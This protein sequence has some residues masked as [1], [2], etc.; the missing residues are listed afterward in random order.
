MRARQKQGGFVATDATSK[1]KY[2]CES[3]SKTC[4][5]PPEELRGVPVWEY[6]LITIVIFL[7]ASLN[8]PTLTLFV[9]P[10]GFVRVSYPCGF[11]VQ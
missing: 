2:N 10:N 5:L 4:V 3:Q 1:S 8:P 7:S 11:A 9:I 6:T